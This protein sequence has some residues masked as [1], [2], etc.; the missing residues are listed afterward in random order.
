MVAHIDL[1]AM[2]A[3]L[4]FSC[5]N[6]PQT[7]IQGQDYDLTPSNNKAALIGCIDSQGIRNIATLS[8]PKDIAGA[9][10]LINKVFSIA[11]AF[12][13]DQS[14]ADVEIPDQVIPDAGLLD[15]TDSEMDF[16]NGFQRVN[17]GRLPCVGLL[18]VANIA[19]GSYAA[20]NP[21][22]LLPSC[23]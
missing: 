21:P 11:K 5:P 12:A 14:V 4:S 15:E 1:V 8:V 3:S 22:A 13:R 9:I 6:Y 18:I 23:P 17:Q 20:T 2:S 16:F 7:F 19:D 10:R